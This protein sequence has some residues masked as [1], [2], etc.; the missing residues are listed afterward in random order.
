VRVV[1]YRHLAGLSISTGII[2]NFSFYLHYNIL[3]IVT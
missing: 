1:G 2:L 3:V